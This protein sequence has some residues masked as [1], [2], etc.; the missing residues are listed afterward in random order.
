[1]LTIVTQASENLSKELNSY[2]IGDVLEMTEVTIDKSHNFNCDT[3]FYNFSNAK[4]L[5]PYRIYIE[6]YKNSLLSISENRSQTIFYNHNDS[7]V[8][9]EYRKPGL[10]LF[11]KA[12]KLSMI[13]PFNTKD[14]I[15]G[16]FLAEGTSGASDFTSR[17]GRHF[18][19]MTDDIDII[20]PD[21]DTIQNMLM[22][23]HHSKEA[24]ILGCD[25]SNSYTQTQNSQIL[26]PDS[27]ESHLLT[28]S[29]IHVT[30]KYEWYASGYRYPVMDIRKHRIYNHGIL[31]DSTT[32]A[33]YFSRSIQE[34][35]IIK[36]PENEALRNEIKNKQNEQLIS[37]GIADE[38]KQKHETIS[39]INE[40]CQIYPTI[41]SEYTTLNYETAP[42]SNIDIM[43]HTPAGQLMWQH[44]KRNAESSG[45]IFCDTVMLDDGEYIITAIIGNK[46][47][48]FKIIKINN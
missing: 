25:F 47:Y 28:D 44:S 36:D 4:Q 16:Y 14:S 41:V 48:S 30:D 13:Y 3:S 11:F 20:T 35:G 32:I 21:G 18:T 17:Q 33:L 27:I 23:S 34:L 10:R 45:R 40:S 39:L 8:I 31:V 6:E 38:N 42:G 19:S 5:A 29:I 9:R 24:I 15:N 1:M 46:R 43:L 7:V 37:R 26:S 22:I 2:R 12:P